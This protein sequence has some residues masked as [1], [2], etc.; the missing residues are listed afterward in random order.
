MLLAPALSAWT[1][2]L[3]CLY[4]TRSPWPAITG[5]YLFG[6]STYE[7]GQLLGGH[8]NL[9][10]ICIVPLIV[11]IVLLHLDGRLSSRRFIVL[12]TAAV[13]GQFLIS[14]EIL[15]TTT[16]LGAATLLVS[17]VVMWGRR[18][19]L[20][21]LIPRILVGYGLAG[22]LLI[23][24]LYLMVAQ[25]IPGRPLNDPFFYSSDVLNF[26]V[27]TPIT[28]VGGTAL[29]RISSSFTG[30]IGEN[31]AYLG[32]PLLG[33]I[34]WFSITHWRN[35]QGKLLTIM[36]A[37]ACLFSLGN[38]L[39]IRGVPAIRLP[40]VPF[41][42]LPIFENVLPARLM[43]YAF[44]VI[45]LMVSIWLAEGRSRKWLRWV[46]VGVSI[47]LLFP[48]V[49][50]GLWHSPAQTPAFFSDALYKKYVSPGEIVLALPM[51]GD[52]M[53]W[54]AQTDFFFRLVGGYT[55]AHPPTEKNYPILSDL[56]FD[57]LPVE[58]AGEF[59]GL[60]A[61]HRVRLVIVRED[62]GL[63]R[64]LSQLL[65]TLPIPVGGVLLYPFPR[66]GLG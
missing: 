20:R 50:A 52:A 31:A 35:V 2:F 51:R 26:V 38:R 40:W 36:L 49:E 62:S 37:V 12:F 57:R 48:N 11:L 39:H 55:G 8:L 19:A 54:Q 14:S 44:L 34:A 53:L 41:A 13:I 16:L 46:V 43:M 24:Y 59:R 60:L 30:N 61:S 10:L 6:F 47:A 64:G 28:L 58:R 9:A 56:F 65:G 7:L 23:P 27:P 4:V 15:L 25:G 45:A 1:A 66:S 21:S 33:I 18:N 42:H 32:L 63:G 22:L 17:V 3:L 29:L 5:G